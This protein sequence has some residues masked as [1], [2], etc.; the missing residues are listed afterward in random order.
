MMLINSH[1]IWQCCLTPTPAKCLQQKLRWPSKS[2]WKV[3]RA[4]LLVTCHRES[5]WY[6][7]VALT[8]ALCLTFQLL[9]NRGRFIT[10]GQKQDRWSGELCWLRWKTIC[11]MLLPPAL[12]EEQLLPLTPALKGEDGRPQ[13][14]MDIHVGSA[15]K[16]K[17]WQDPD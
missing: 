16:R 3:L 17:R 8:N 12:K 13:S 7:E 2:R 10:S 4:E 1:P 5:N 9:Q 11:T 15:R 6:S 14:C